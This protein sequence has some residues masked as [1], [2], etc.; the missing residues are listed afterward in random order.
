MTA[1]TPDINGILRAHM[2]VERYR[3]EL[4]VSL[5]AVTAGCR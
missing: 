5:A 1:P 2:A 4:E 3:D